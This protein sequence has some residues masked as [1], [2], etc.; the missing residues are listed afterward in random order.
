MPES[1]HFDS[2][3]VGS[4]ISGGWSAK[5]LCEKGLKT[6]VLERDR[7]V[8]H[9][10]DYPTATLN[11]WQFKNRGQ[12]DA[13]ERVNPIAGGCYAF[14]ETTKHFFV[15]DK[16]HPYVQE[17]PFYGILGYRAGGK[18]LIWAL[19]TQRS[20]KYDFEGRQGWLCG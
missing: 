9:L 13:I 8:E 2:I 6:R 15:K 20:S 4:G 19:A 17:K 5:E 18:S 3:V 7:M 16:E 1:N 14:D 10:K 11:P 12:L